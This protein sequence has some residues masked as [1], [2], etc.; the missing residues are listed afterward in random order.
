MCP[1]LKLEVSQNSSSENNIF[2]YHHMTIWL[3]NFLLPNILCKKRDIEWGNYLLAF[4][5]IITSNGN[6]L[7]MKD[8]YILFKNI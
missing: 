8:F 3:F 2:L 7:V 4:I 5:E 1:N 6:L